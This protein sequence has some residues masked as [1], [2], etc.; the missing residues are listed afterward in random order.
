MFVYVLIVCY[1]NLLKQVWKMQSYRLISRVR[2]WKDKQVVWPPENSG[3]NISFVLS[4][5]ILLAQ[6]TAA[7]GGK[8]IQKWGR[9]KLSWTCCSGWKCYA[10]NDLYAQC[11]SSCPAGWRCPVVTTVTTTKPTT[12]TKTTTTTTTAATTTITAATTTTAKQCVCNH[13]T[14]AQGMLCLKHGDEI[15]TSCDAGYTL[16]KAAC[17]GTCALT[18]FVRN[19]MRVRASSCWCVCVLW[20]RARAWKG[21]DVFSCLRW[22]HS[23][24]AVSGH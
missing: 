22:W 6:F 13:G 8:C 11:R 23:S 4:F 7:R 5:S 21:I 19:A 18:L 16:T 14:P 9:C 12:T 3:M 15:W 2:G 20:E 24:W 10:Q 17:L 1:H